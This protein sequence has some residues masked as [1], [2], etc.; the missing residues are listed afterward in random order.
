[1]N[2]MPLSEIRP[3]QGR[4]GLMSEALEKARYAMELGFPSISALLGKY[5]GRKF[6]IA[7]SGPSLVD[8]LPEIRRQL[9]LSKRTMIVAV[10]KSHDWLLSKGVPPERMI[11][12]IIDPKPWVATY[13]TPTK[14]VTY[15]LGSKLHRDTLDRFKGHS[16]AYLFHMWEFVEEFEALCKEYAHRFDIVSIPGYSTV[17]LRAFNVGYD[18]GCREFECHGFDSSHK[19]N[20]PDLEI[21]D[22]THAFEKNV[23]RM[24][25]TPECMVIDD[26]TGRPRWYY[27]D[28]HMARQLKEFFECVEGFDER[29]KNES[30]AQPIKVTIA[31]HGALPFGVCCRAREGST[32]VRHVNPAWNKDPHLMPGGLRN[33]PQPEPEPDDLRCASIMFPGI[34][35]ADGPAANHL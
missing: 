16:G 25:N 26:K 1:M 29:A 7:G 18:L 20:A 35:F 8:T 30:D 28:M 10:N 33:N 23:P 31:G 21:K 17:G 22:A 11:G 6:I 27:T 5:T 2:V 14:G 3:G 13:M 24:D 15:C 4:A 12:L 34:T 32:N 19:D 9:R